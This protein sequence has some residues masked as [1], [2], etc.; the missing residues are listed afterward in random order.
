MLYVDDKVLFLE[1]ITENQKTLRKWFW[2]INDSK[3]IAYSNDNVLV[4]INCIK[5]ETFDAYVNNLLYKKSFN[6]IPV[7]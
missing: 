4:Y 6:K 3:S 1:I 7:N 2:N 5:G